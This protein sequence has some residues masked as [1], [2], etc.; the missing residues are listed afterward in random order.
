M[1]TIFAKPDD[2]KENLDCRE[3]R[4]GIF[5]CRSVTG[6]VAFLSNPQL[7]IN[8]GPNPPLEKHLEL[9]PW[10]ITGCWNQVLQIPL[11]TQAT[12]WI[13]LGLTAHLNITRWTAHDIGHYIWFILIKWWLPLVIVIVIVLLLVL[14]LKVHIKI[15]M[16]FRAFLQCVI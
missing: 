8:W 4:P 11:G 10:L 1:A 12:Q 2:I 14:F 16:F 13:F 6:V 9:D 5:V 3:R 7:S 15:Y